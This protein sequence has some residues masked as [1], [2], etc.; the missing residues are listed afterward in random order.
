MAEFIINKEI[1]T[2]VPDIEVTITV[3]NA[4][5]IGRNTFQLVVVDDS[6]NRS[7]PDEVTVFVADQT[8]PNAVL[9]APKVVGTG[10]SFNLDGSKS[11]DLGGGK[12]VQY[13]WTYLG[14]SLISTPPAIP[15]TPVSPGTIRN[16]IGGIVSPIVTPL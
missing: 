10:A 16:P 11:F 15:V 4:L 7:K 3:N 1:V 8:A 5:P 13:I 6:G 12:V 14:T 9:N 2:D